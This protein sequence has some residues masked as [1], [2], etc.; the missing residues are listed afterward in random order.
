M[1]YFT[2][3]ED[4]VES[5][6]CIFFINIYL[7]ILRLLIFFSYAVSFLACSTTTFV[8]AVGGP[9]FECSNSRE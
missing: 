7:A 2:L 5:K 9:N 3:E 1:P 8:S 6:R 4:P